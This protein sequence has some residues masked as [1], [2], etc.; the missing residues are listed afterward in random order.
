MNFQALFSPRGV[1]VFGSVAPGKLGNVLLNRLVEG[2][3]EKVFAVNPKAQGIGDI[4]GFTSAQEIEEPVD[5]GVIVSPAATVCGVMEDC[6]KAGI[7]A[8]II[9]TSGFAETG[10]LTGE[11]QIKEIADRY[12]IGFIG[13]NCAGLLNMHHGLLATLEAA[14]PKGKIALISQSGS[15]GGIMMSCAAD[16]GL[17]ISKFVSYGNANGLN[18]MDFLQFLQDDPE[19]DVIALYLENIKNG[20]DFMEVL[21]QTTKKKPVVIVKSGR[22]ASGQRAT[23]SHTGSMAGADGVYDAALKECGAI[24]ASDI[25]ELLDICKGF[26]MLPPMEG[27]QLLV[28]TNSG[29]PAIM[30]VDAGEE[31]GLEIGEPAEQVKDALRQFLKPHASLKNPLDLTVEGTPEEYYKTTVTALQDYDAALVIYVGTPYLVSMPYA[32]NIVKA[33]KASGKPVLSMFAVGVDLEESKEFLQQSGVPIYRTGERAVRA[34]QGLWQYRQYLNRRETPVAEQAPAGRLEMP[35]VPEPMAMTLLHDHGISIPEMAMTHKAGEVAALCRKIG[36]PVVIKVVSPD[37]IHKSDCGG[38]RLNIQNDQE[39]LAAFTQMEQICQGK[40]FG[41]V[42]IYPMLEK[43]VEVLLGLTRDVQ[44]GPVVVCGLGGIYSEVLKDIALRVAPV[45]KETALEMVKSLRCYPI[46]TGSRGKE[47]LD[48]AAL[49]EAI[50]NFS[51]LPFLYPDLKEA[52]LN[53]VMVYPEGV[54]TADVRLLGGK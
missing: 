27:N 51:Q 39:A 15:I 44:F 5:L 43:G 11:A 35:V 14:P 30:S 53:P 40:R 29:G 20:R 8:V 9:I 31:R 2:G 18:E 22:T 24:R 17:G 4:P 48:V 37:I 41:G 47:P 52:D 46:L 34:L 28:L 50:A 36:Y 21:R 19:T 10:N 7:K 42:V 1:A 23:L 38:V 32:E 26:A 6:G 33:A 3:T 45:G 16:E 54:V 12:G 13:P 25:E 49:A